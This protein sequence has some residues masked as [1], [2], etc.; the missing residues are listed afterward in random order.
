MSMPRIT[1]CCKLRI[2]TKSTQHSTPE[3]Y[4]VY[5]E[6]DTCPATERDVPFVDTKRG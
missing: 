4:L 1:E 2:T 5:T 3:I 6:I